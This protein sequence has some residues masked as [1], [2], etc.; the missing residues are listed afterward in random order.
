M[1]RGPSRVEP[2]DAGVLVEFQI[3]PDVRETGQ[4]SEPFQRVV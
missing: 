1:V 4:G 2:T 3:E